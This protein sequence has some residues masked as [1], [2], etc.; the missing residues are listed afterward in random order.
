MATRTMIAIRIT[1]LLLCLLTVVTMFNAC[2]RG[3]VSQDSST[4]DNSKENET[5][6]LSE[7]TLY[8]FSYSESLVIKDDD[9]K[10]LTTKDNTEPV[11]CTVT[12]IPLTYG[13]WYGDKH[14]TSL[15]A[16]KEGCW[17]LK[18]DFGFPALLES[19]S[20]TFASSGTIPE[21]VEV[22]LS[23]DGYNFNDYAGDAEGGESDDCT[24]FTLELDEEKTV[25]AVKFYVYSAVG[26][27][28]AVLSV[29]CIGK[30]VTEK[31]LLSS[32]AKYT[33]DGVSD[34]RYTKYADDGM[35]LT[36]GA[37]ENMIFNSG[38]ASVV[39]CA[40]TDELT[41]RSV[42]NVVIDLE[43]QCNVS[44]VIM[45]TCKNTV[46]ELGIKRPEFASVKYSS[47]GESWEDFCMSFA[48]GSAVDATQRVKRERTTYSMMRNHTVSARYIKVQIFTSD[49][50]AINE[51]SVYGSDEAVAEP[52]YVFASRSDAAIVTDGLEYT[53]NGVSLGA[54][55]VCKAAPDADGNI[56]LAVTSQNASITAAA[57]CI[58]GDVDSL[59]FARTE[60]VSSRNVAGTD[61]YYF[62]F[63]ENEQPE[64]VIKSSAAVDITLVALYEGGECLP[65]IRGGFYSFFI[66]GIEGYNAHHYFDTYRTYIQLKGFRELGMDTVILSGQNLMYDDKITLI[67]PPAE[68]AAKGYTKG[69][70]H[71]VYDLNE[72]LLS[73]C[74][75]LGI[76]VYLSTVLSLAYSQLPASYTKRDAYLADVLSDAEIIIKYVYDKYK[77][78]KSFYGFYF[79]DETCDAWLGQEKLSNTDYTRRLYAGQSKVVRELDE[80][81]MIAIAP[82][83]WR[84][85]TPKAFGDNLRDLIK[86]ETEGGRPIIDVVMVQDCLGREQSIEVTDSVY[87]KYTE[88]LKEC[89]RKVREAGAEFMN[90]TEIFDIGYRIKRGD[91][92]ISS[93]NL[94]S[95]L[96]T[97]THVFDLTHY[98]SSQGRGSYDG[99]SYFDNDCITT[100]YAKYFASMRGLLYGSE[101]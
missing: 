43:K 19:A 79:V 56:T 67:D 75:K 100:R 7:N 11:V 72:A 98:F 16:E 90:D 32:G 87:E 83:A 57:V 47:D 65:L 1:A 61:Y 69:V 76:N 52:E 85:D 26:T 2:E 27:E 45:T 92:I 23:D 20:I 88:Y 78:H 91:E 93:V 8:F 62:F 12:D 53:L 18:N 74:D 97:S 5:M 63:E 25:K 37:S 42:I 44:E 38:E 6:D 14:T 10:Q 60:P 101:D 3:T 77:D 94:E 81:L 50:V 86:N 58:D 4:T 95:T 33:I 15:F 66:N 22:Y 55:A 35:R 54:D 21:R 80:S 24:V 64:L 40:V 59:T 17:Y 31:R 68:L 9:G 41:G 28:N 89:A 71:G 96:T 84:C 36:D 29:N 73:A 34:A 82:A 39:R 49:T 46:A 99:Y 30:R 51:I 48:E 70:G 13:D